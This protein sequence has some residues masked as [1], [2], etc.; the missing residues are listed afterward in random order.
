MSVVLFF[1]LAVVAAGIILYP[2]LPGRTAARPVRAVTDG[3]IERAVHD[4]RQ[5]ATKGG[6]LCPSCG[7]AFDAQDRFCVRCGAAL[8]GREREA[9][10]APAACPSCG[11]PL[12][13][14]DQFCAKCGHRLAGGEVA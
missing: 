4:L 9:A 1:L 3:D 7:H 12:R 6:Q 10:V 2:L 14:G 8:P 5:P 13:P 11:A